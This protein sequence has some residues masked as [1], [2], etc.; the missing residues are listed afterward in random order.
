M[1]HRKSLCVIEQ[2]LVYEVVRKIADIVPAH[3]VANEAEL[4]KMAPTSHVLAP[5]RTE[6][7]AQ[8]R[9]SL[10]GGVASTRSEGVGAQRTDFLRTALLERFGE[11][12]T[13]AVSVIAR[14]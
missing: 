8:I 14:C 7:F 9:P 13:Q 5:E 12:S 10:G 2:K 3:T 4:L 11:T 6:D 1:A